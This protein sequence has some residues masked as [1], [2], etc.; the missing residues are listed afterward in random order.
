LAGGVFK[1][2]LKASQYCD[3]SA[4]IGLVLLS[5]SVPTAVLVALTFQTNTVMRRLITE[6]RP[7][8]CVVRRF[9][10]YANVIESS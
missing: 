1:R 7:E 9:H 8:K 4:M 10:R 6:I 3:D 2:R 5:V